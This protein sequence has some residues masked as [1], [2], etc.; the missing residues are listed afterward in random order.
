[1]QNQ[2]HVQP[3]RGHSTEHTG[4]S[5]PPP[6]D[7][8]NT[9]A[10]RWTNLADSR[11]E[12]TSGPGKHQGGSGGVIPSGNTGLKPGEMVV[13]K[14]QSPEAQALQPQ[15]K[16]MQRPQSRDGD[17]AFAQFQRLPTHAEPDHPVAA[18]AVGI[19]TVEPANS[20]E[21]PSTGSTS[22]NMGLEPEGRTFKRTFHM[23][24]HLPNGQHALRVGCLDTMADLDAVSHH[25]VESL[26]LKKDRY[27][28]PPV[29]PLG[30]YFEPQSQVTVDW[31]VYKFNKTYTTTFAALDE[32]HSGDFDVL[33]GHRTIEKIGFY[34]KNGRVWMLSAN[35]PV[36]SDRE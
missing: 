34:E 16:H 31:H 14:S 27:F 9:Q 26:G 13:A 23:V 7:A 8:E 29:R 18:P 10:E 30:G 5:N 3:S 1:M 17:F 20:K 4:P 22:S 28:G 2:S 33:L 11:Q 36:G 6:T 21:P 35:D 12:A 32:R 19:K 25:V 15:S 24:I